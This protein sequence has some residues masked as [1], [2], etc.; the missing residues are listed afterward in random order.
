MC[1]PDLAASASCFV[2]HESGHGTIWTII[3]VAGLL[4][5]RDLL[6]LADRLLEALLP[7]WMW[8]PGGLRDT[9]MRDWRKPRSGRQAWW[10]EGTGLD[11]DGR[12]S[13][14]DD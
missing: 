11:P 13:R 2:G 7:D 9:R 14:L 6:R 10:V 8:G 5:A 3:L 12:A 1:D 4:V